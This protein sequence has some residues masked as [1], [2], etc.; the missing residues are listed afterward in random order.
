MLPIML[1]SVGFSLMMGACAGQALAPFGDK[2]GTASALL[3][4][5]QMTGASVI[6]GLL[7]LT[8]LD[9]A[10]QL[11]VLMLSIMPMY[12][13]YKTPSIKQKITFT[14]STIS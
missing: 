14:E 12:C 4:F 7:Q 1:S 13:L 5:A 9:A 3:G 6:V 10:Q 8:G 2:A 11:I